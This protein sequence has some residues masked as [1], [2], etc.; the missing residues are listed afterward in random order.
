MA[1]EL[2][3]VLTLGCIAVGL[4]VADRIYRINP[5]LQKEG[6][7]SGGGYRR[8]G[9]GHAPCDF[10]TRCMN[11]ICRGTELSQLHDRN[12]LPVL[13]VGPSILS[14]PEPPASTLPSAWGIALPQ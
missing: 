11:G 5:Y 6:F 2:Y 3:A 13:P 10:G 12:P 8:C 14:G 4:L 7:T 1:T 9:A